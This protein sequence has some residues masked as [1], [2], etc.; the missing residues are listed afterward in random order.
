MNESGG[1]GLSEYF[2]RALSTNGAVCETLIDSEYS[3]QPV[4]ASKAGTWSEVASTKS[5]HTGTATASSSGSGFDPNRYGNPGARS[6]SGSVHSF[7]SSVVERSQTG[8]DRVEMRNGF[9]RIKAYVSDY[10]LFLF[11]NVTLV[12]KQS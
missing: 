5:W 8:S 7:N 4:K 10:R 9:A 6:V 2:Q 1:V 3:Y 11:A 12:C